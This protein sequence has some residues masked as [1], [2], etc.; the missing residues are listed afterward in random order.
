M[1]LVNR[2]FRARYL[3]RAEDAVFSSR[4]KTSSASALA[5]HVVFTGKRETQMSKP[6]GYMFNVYIRKVR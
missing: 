2:K 5:V 6:P 3:L 1:Y 4:R